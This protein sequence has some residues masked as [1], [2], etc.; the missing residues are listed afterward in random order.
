MHLLIALRQVGV[1]VELCKWQ[2]ER[3][4]GIH[5]AWVAQLIGAVAWNHDSTIQA[6]AN[7]SMYT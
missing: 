5:G 1:E 4:G 3:R 2:M 7:D 6:V